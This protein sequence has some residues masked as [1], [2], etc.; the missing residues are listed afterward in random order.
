MDPLRSLI[1]LALSKVQEHW[2]PLDQSLKP[3]IIFVLR[4]YLSNTRDY[5][6]T[7]HYVAQTLGTWIPVK[8]LYDIL[9]VPD[10]PLPDPGSSPSSSTDTSNARSK[11]R[12]W[13]EVE[14][15]RLLA[16]IYR[17]GLKDWGTVAKF[18]GN[19]R[20]TGQCSQRWQRCL[21]SDIKKELW[22]EEEELKL[23]SL[24]KCYGKSSWTKVAARLP[25]RTDVQCRYR[26]N[27]LSDA[28]DH[29]SRWEKVDAYSPQEAPLPLRNEYAP[30]AVP[31]FMPYPP[32]QQACFVMAV[33][34]QP[35]FPM[36]PEL[37]YQ[38]QFQA[39]P[40]F[41]PQTFPF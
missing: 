14:D 28:P 32:Q 29:K 4:E 31:A 3:A 40:V 1:D 38:P 34:C 21:N 8:F 17:Y 2:K 10:A 16:G 18:I 26:F 30:V 37:F 33:P 11:T 22:S 27:L 36:C 15:F 12:R 24:V 41:C 6:S 13:D 35:P 9:Q 20:A 39:A 7:Y 23:F 19:G 5:T 25:N